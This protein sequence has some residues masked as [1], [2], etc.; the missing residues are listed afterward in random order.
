[1]AAES[2][3]MVRGA[4]WEGRG[5]AGRAHSQR[6]HRPPPPTHARAT[7][8]RPS[9]DN[10]P[11]I[12]NNNNA[13][14]LYEERAAVVT[15]KKAVAGGDGKGVPGFWQTVFLRCDATRDAMNE[16]DVDV[17]AYLTDVTVRWQ[18]T[19]FGQSRGSP[20]SLERTQHAWSAACMERGMHEVRVP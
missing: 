19:V 10:T 2:G 5:A 4:A 1:M 12:K 17:L 7:T 14:P 16:K 8:Q 15:G 3:R 13:A 11:T 20:G 18:S 6:M 9:F